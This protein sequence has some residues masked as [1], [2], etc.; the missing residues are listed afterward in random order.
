M[1]YAEWRILDHVADHFPANCYPHLRQLLR[2]RAADGPPLLAVAARYFF[3]IEVQAD[4]ALVRDL[5]FD[6]LGR[7]AKSQQAGFDALNELLLKHADRLDD[8]L[9]S[10]AQTHAAVLDLRAEQG[11]WGC[12]LHEIYDQLIDLKSKLDLPSPRF[13]PRDTLSIRTSAERKMVRKLLARFRALPLEQQQRAPALLNGLGMLEA[14]AAQS[15]DDPG[16]ASARQI[17]KEVAAAVPDGRVGPPRHHPG[18]RC[19]LRRRRPRPPVPGDGL[20]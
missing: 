2:L 4:A 6:T 9:G 5:S 18:A 13:R 10:L 7:V 17:F 15:P 3:R 16:L 8:L 1:L 11:R 20:L 19:Q 12:Q 14:A